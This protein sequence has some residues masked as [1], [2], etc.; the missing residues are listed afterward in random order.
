MKNIF[1]LFLSTTILFCL[2]ISKIDAQKKTQSN[3]EFKFIENKGQWDSTVKFATDIPG[4]KIYLKNTGITYAIIDAKGITDARHHQSSKNTRAKNSELNKI[5]T[6]H[7]DFIGAANNPTVISKGESEA[8]YNFYLGNDT[9]KW[10]DNCKAYDIVIYKEIYPGV[11]LKFY[12]NQS[13][14]KYDFILQKG[15][16]P[17]VIKFKY[18][19]VENFKLE[20]KKLIATTKYN[21][22]IE[23]VPYSYQT[24]K[25]GNI[26]EVACNYV[27]SNNT[28]G[29]SF[30]KGYKKTQAITIDPE[31]IFSTFSGSTAD[32]FG[33]TACFDSAG[34][35]YS[36]GIVFGIGLPSTTDENFSGGLTDIGILKY[37]STGSMLL[38]ATYIGGNSED[39]PHSLVV[40]NNNE[41]VIMGSTGSAN[42]PTSANAFDRTFNGGS[43]FNVF[44]ASP[45]GDYLNGSD[46]IISKLDNTGKLIA[47]TFVGG[48]GNDAVLKI[49]ADGRYVNKLIRNYGDYFRGDIIFDEQNNIYVASSTDAID[50]PVTSSIQDAYGGGNSDAVI[51]SLNEDL[52]MMRWSTYL[53]GAGDDAAYSVKL[54][55]KNN[56]YI[57][58]GT[59]S[60]TFPTTTN[61]IDPTYNGGIDGFIT[62]IDQV[63]DSIRH[64]TFL[65]TTEYDQAYFIDL[66]MHENVYAFG[67]TKGDYLVTAD[68]YN[69]PNSGQFIQKITNSLDSTIFSTVFG[70]GTK[71]PNISP[72][73]FLTNE[74]DNIFLSGWGGATNNSNTGGLNTGNTFNMPITNDALF[75]TT[76]GSDFYLMALSSDGKKLLYATFFGATNNGGDHVDGGTSRFDKRGIIY[77][78]V[79]SCGGSADNFPTTKGAWSEVNKGVNSGGVER[80][81][82]ASFKFDLATL[83]ARIET[84][85][86]EETELGLKEGCTPLDILFLNKSINGTEYFWDFGNGN[87]ST[88]K[89]RII[90]TYDEPGVYQVILRVRDINTCQIEDIAMTTITVHEGNFAI[91]ED[92]EICGGDEV[93]INASGG[94]NYNWIQRNGDLVSKIANPIVT[95]DTTTTYFV[96]VTDSN[97][98]FFEDSVRVGVVPEVIADFEVK[99]LYNCKSMPTLS[100]KNISQNS[101]SLRWDFGDGTTSNEP[102]PTHQFPDTLDYTVTLLAMSNEKC[103]NQKSV[104]VSNEIIFVPNVVTLNNDGKNEKFIIDT[105]TPLEITIV[106][107]WGKK[108][109]QA[110]NYYN[111]WPKK[112]VR[113]GIYY[114]DIIF[115][116]GT[117]CNGWVQVLK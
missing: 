84:D 59:A 91:G 99:K 34:N 20:E 65:G 13:Y 55:S 70:S 47:S 75:K 63:G 110:K 94:V 53:G 40:N 36:G 73:A 31:L 12:A 29:F 24:D 79:C 106:N 18:S 10:A 17:R 98:C 39:N 115:P 4:G 97:G 54:D 27:V 76:D 25:R 61:T 105:Q 101:D 22:I 9:T 49:A 89:D 56:I 67:Q 16:D 42:Y 116:D 30:P 15:V 57:G 41:L 69:N 103:T 2:F 33:Y 71:E 8:V 96:T 104:L 102:N 72:T 93:R 44:G 46:I 19:G 100:F 117:S 109:H 50:F 6:T 90:N 11:D 112:D 1:K 3:S 5:H 92:K 64:S 43:L 80:C 51:F 114:Y 81:N 35:L 111:E 83:V 7:V 14:L 45:Q 66:D 21:T 85:N 82:N 26:K 87:T 58:G 38:Y 113:A 28:V 78:S 68:T 86:P 23:N 95:P 32:N 60:N 88:E 52:S 74:C 37:D 108:L 107:R 77:Q 62:S 48:S